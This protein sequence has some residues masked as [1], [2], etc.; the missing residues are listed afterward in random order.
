M[1]PTGVL[2]IA[3]LEDR[4]KARQAI[5]HLAYT[6]LGS[7]ILYIEM[8]PP[9]LWSGDMIDTEQTSTISETTAATS[10]AVKENA[11]CSLFVK[12]LPKGNVR[13]A[14][15]QAFRR[16]GGFLS[17]TVPTP[18]KDASSHLQG[19]GFVHFE[20]GSQAAQAMSGMQ[21]A[22]IGGRVIEVEISQARSQS[23]SE[24]IDGAANLA[25]NTGP[26]SAKTRSLVLKNLPFEATRKDLQDILR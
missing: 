20:T 14:L 25:T 6:R 4:S 13:D 8:A 23:S 3:E 5:E 15:E 26:S 10:S 7:S 19:F 21:G 9:G 22:V 12:N 1:V 11:S 18:G 2:A 17:C 16:F 24:P